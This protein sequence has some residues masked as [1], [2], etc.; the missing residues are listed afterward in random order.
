M[1]NKFADVQSVNI[2]EGTKIWQYVVILP[3]ATIGRNCNINCHCFIENDVVIGDDVTLKSGV[4]LWD[5]VSIGDR[6]FIGPCVTFTNDLY[7]RS[8]Q[9]LFPFSKT[10]IGESVSIGANAT[11]IAGLSIGSFALIGAGSVV[12]NDIPDHCI[13]YGNPARHHGYACDCG[14]KLDNSLK[15]KRCGTQYYIDSDGLIV[16][17]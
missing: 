2:G 14:F 12:T 9:H 16:R 1:I 10:I 5:G 17:N 8:K 3:G 4:Y 11:I 15:C 6:S 13:Y 7:P